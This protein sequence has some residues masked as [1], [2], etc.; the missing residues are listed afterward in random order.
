MSLETGWEL[1]ENSPLIIDRYR[2]TALALGYSGDSIINSVSDTLAMTMGFLAASRV[3]MG[4]IVTL[5]LFFE[6]YTGYMIRD[7]LTLNVVQLIH[8]SEVISRWQSSI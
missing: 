3:S 6:V 5:A 1:L 8:P 7:N 2:E 4:Y